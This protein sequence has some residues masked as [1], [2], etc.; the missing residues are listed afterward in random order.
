[1][2]LFSLPHQLLNEC[3]GKKKRSTYAIQNN[4]PS[5]RLL[6]PLYILPWLEEP[7]AIKLKQLKLFWSSLTPVK[8]F[9]SVKNSK[10]LGYLTGI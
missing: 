6:K 1:M 10:L 9:N 5:C 2:E 8:Y 4:N 7:Q 3:W